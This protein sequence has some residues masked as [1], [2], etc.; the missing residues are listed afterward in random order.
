MVGLA[1]IVVVLLCWLPSAAAPNDGRMPYPFMG[2]NAWALMPGRGQPTEAELIQICEALV[3]TGLRDAGYIYISPGEIGFVRDLATQVIKLE[4]P[5]HF[6]GGD[7]K[8]FSAYLHA[9]GFKLSQGISPGAKS[10]TGEVGV[11]GPRPANETYPLPEHCHAAA[12]AK[13]MA[14]QGSDHW[15]C[16]WCQFICKHNSSC[17]VE[18]FGRVWDAIESTGRNMTLGIYIYGKSHPETWAPSIGHYWR[19]GADMK[20]AWDNVIGEV[21][22]VIWNDVARQANGPGAYNMLDALVVGAPNNTHTGIAGPGLSINEATS[23]MSLWVVLASP[24]LLG[25]DIRKP[26][27]P[28][29]MQILTNPEVLAVHKDSLA[30]QGRPVRTK[31]WSYGHCVDPQQSDPVL[32]IEKPLANNDTALLIL[33]RGGQGLSGNISI[34]FDDLYTSWSVHPNTCLPQSTDMHDVM[35]LPRR[36]VSI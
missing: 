6:T 30:K 3:K 14:E 20:N 28:E 32:A 18:H 27:K 16:D 34:D 22:E 8:H 26:I 35:S 7:L 11:C 13:W 31:R 10:C 2:F 23:H 24:L 21:D 9:N 33:N 17:Y 12:D 4:F 29:I 25:F 19:M 36:T 5:E 15:P 1:L